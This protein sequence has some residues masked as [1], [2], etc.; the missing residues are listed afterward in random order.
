MNDRQQDIPAMTHFRATEEASSLSTVPLLSP[1]LEEI[2]LL[3]AVGSI[4]HL[5]APR[6]RGISSRRQRSSC[7]LALGACIA[8]SRWIYFWMIL[9]MGRSFG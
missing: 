4:S 6:E 3:F 9:P 1:R 2:N 8:P 5:T 7:V